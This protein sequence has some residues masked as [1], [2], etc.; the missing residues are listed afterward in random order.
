[1][2]CVGQRI[3][4]LKA[5][6]HSNK[7]SGSFGWCGFSRV[8]PLLQRWVVAIGTMGCCRHLCA[9]QRPP[10]SASLWGL[11]WGR[12]LREGEQREGWLGR[13]LGCFSALFSP[14]AWLWRKAAGQLSPPRLLNRILSCV[15]TP[16]ILSLVYSCLFALSELLP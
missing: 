15:C 12:T 2:S 7:P 8:F 14:H 5:S 4:E 11:C 9:G 16:P 6:L 1:M 3:K 10:T 13:I